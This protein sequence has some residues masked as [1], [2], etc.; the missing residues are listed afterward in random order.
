MGK[1]VRQEQDLS[2]LTWSNQ[3]LLLF[4][5][6]Q[7]NQVASLNAISSLGMFITFMIMQDLS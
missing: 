6:S 1:I 5:D 3:T 4:T 7:L 2:Q